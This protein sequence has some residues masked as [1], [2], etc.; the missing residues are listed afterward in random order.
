MEEFNAVNI[1]TENIE[2]PEQEF[3]KF[4][5]QVNFNTLDNIFREYEN[6]AKDGAQ[7]TVPFPE[8]SKDSVVLSSMG[9][10]LSKDRKAYLNRSYFDL[11]E[12]SIE[13]HILNVPRKAFVFRTLTHELSHV[14]SKFRQTDSGYTADKK[15]EELYM[16]GYF[17]SKSIGYTQVEK[18]FKLL[19]EAVIEK[20]AQQVVLE[21]LE[22]EKDFL[23]KKEKEDYREWIKNKGYPYSDDVSLLDSLISSISK[24]ITIPENDV[25][26]A[27]IRGLFEENFLNDKEVQEAFSELYS[28]DFLK[29]LTNYKDQFSGVVIENKE[30][31]KRILKQLSSK[32][33][34]IDK[35]IQKLFK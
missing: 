30:A 35:I 28:E 18:S 27:F 5:E 11:N 2:Q 22:R 13:K 14:V 19:N 7:T 26:N 21:Y 33:S 17:T 1:K 6:F 23:T 29:D 24:K 15:R 32:A 20:F 10:F 31:S 25:W 9:S 34:L 12:K 8:I 16:T 3:Y 4:L